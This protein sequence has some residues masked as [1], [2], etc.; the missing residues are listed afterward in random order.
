MT[1]RGRVLHLVSYLLRLLSIQKKY[2]TGLV[3][4]SAKITAKVVNFRL[5]CWAIRSLVKAS[6]S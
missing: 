2:R 6:L 4:V 3:S 1:N 5:K